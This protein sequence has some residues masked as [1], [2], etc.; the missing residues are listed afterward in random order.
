MNGPFLAGGEVFP[1]WMEER[2]GKIPLP[3][4]E[5][6]TLGGHAICIVGYSRLGKFFKFKN[7]WGERWGETGYGY[8]PF[9]YLDSYCRDAW[10]AT[11][12]IA[13]PDSLAQLY[14]GRGLDPAERD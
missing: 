9:D 3:G 5:A 6:Q 12:L 4:E 1:E 10:S 13:H 14:R 7:S 8:L 2:G 11:D